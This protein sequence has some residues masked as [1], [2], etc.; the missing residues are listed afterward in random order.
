MNVLQTKPSLTSRWKHWGCGFG[1]AACAGPV[2]L[3]QLLVDTAR[4]LASNA[5]LLVMAV[6]WLA[7][8]H[9]IVDVDQLARL[10]D[11]LRGRDSAR[12]GLILETA[13]QFVGLDVFQKA[14]EVCQP[15]DP[16][17]PLYEL[18]RSRPALARL[19]Q[20]RAGAIS[21]RW[22][23]WCEPIDAL[24]YNALRP[25]SWIIHR[26]ATFM[27]RSLLKGDVRC[28]VITALGEEGLVEVSE[29]ELTRRAGCTRR[30]MHL[31]LENL[32][33]SGLIVRKRQGRRYAISLC[34]AYPSS[35]PA[36]GSHVP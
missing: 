7:R 2:N 3:E 31:A 22:G 14:I 5:R 30:A 35:V 11:K 29:T 13:Q 16:P 9:A 24:K 12:L 19:A 36:P 18:D 20:R 21:R 15:W 33:A 8:H 17:E 10:A 32:D 1:V 28:K 27:L 26:N 4:E 6:T 23:L 34:R 25:A